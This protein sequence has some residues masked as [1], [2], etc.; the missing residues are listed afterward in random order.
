M[1][2]LDAAPP[3]VRKYFDEVMNQH[4]LDELDQL[5]TRDYVNHS[6]TPEA[7]GVVAEREMDRMMFGAFPDGKMEVE[8]VICDGDR[9]AIR[10]KWCGTHKGQFMG[11]APTNQSFCMRGTS[12][13]RLSDGLIA[14]NWSCFDQSQFLQSLGIGT[15]PQVNQ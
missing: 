15:T 5:V 13:L 1:Q 10:A 2:G 12:I 7:V 6:M 4:R 11:V 14:E 9:V 8:D 3:V